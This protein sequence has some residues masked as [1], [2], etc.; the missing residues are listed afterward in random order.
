M[1]NLKKV[2]KKYITIILVILIFQVQ[3]ASAAICKH[4]TQVSKQFLAAD[5]TVEFQYDID[6]E[7]IG[8]VDFFIYLSSATTFSPTFQVAVDENP[9][10]MTTAV[11]YTFPS[12]PGNNDFGSD[13]AQL[14]SEGPNRYLLS[15]EFSSYFSFADCG[16]LSAPQLPAHRTVKVTISGL[17]VNGHLQVNA[18]S[19]GC[20]SENE[21]LVLDNSAVNFTE[22]TTCPSIAKPID[23]VLVLDVS[24]SMTEL[25]STESVTL[26]KIDILHEASNLFLNT[27]ASDT[28]CDANDRAGA[29]FFETTASPYFVAGS[30][31]VGPPTNWSTLENEVLMHPTGNTTAMGDG[32]QEAL[33][34][35]DDASNNLRYIILFTNGMQNQGNLVEDSGPP[36]FLKTLN[37][38]SLR[39][40]GIPIYT[41]GAGV[42]TGSAYEELLE[43]IAEQTGVTSTFT[44]T[45]ADDLTDAFWQ[46]LIA[47]MRG[48]SPAMV[49]V[50]AGIINKGDTSITHTFQVNRAAKSGVFIVG[51]HA[52]SNEDR[53]PQAITMEVVGPNT[54]G[55]LTQG[56]LRDDRHFHIRSVSF[57][58]SGFSANAHEGVWKIII[59]SKNMKGTKAYYHTA[60][61]VDEAKLDYRVGAAPSDYGTGEDILLTASL[62]VEGQPVKNADP[63][64]CSV[65]RPK[66]P[67]GTFLNQR[68]LSDSQLNNNPPGVHE[69]NFPNAYSRKLYRLIV[70]QGLGKLLEPI[71]ETKPIALYDDG[72]EELHGDA[73]AGDGIYSV[74]YKNT[75]IP[76]QYKFNFSI[77]G[78]HAVIGKFS[79]TEESTV[80]VRVKTADP[81]ESEIY[82]D[83]LLS[84]DKLLTVVPADRFGNFLGPGYDNEV[85]ITTNNP[86]VTVTA[87]KDERVNGTYTT[88]LKNVPPGADPEVTVMVRGKELAKKPLSQWVLPPKWILGGYFGRNLP[89]KNLD[90][91]YNPGLSIEGVLE[92]LFSNRVAVFASVGYNI[93]KHDIDVAG[94]VPVDLKAINVSGNLKVYPVIGTFQLSIFGGGGYYLFDP[95][96]DK[97]G[98]NCGTAAEL[99]ISTNFSIEAKCNYNYVFTPI[100]KTIFFTLQGGLRYRF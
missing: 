48:N 37:G 27:W 31:L 17:T 42:T 91:L 5:G 12:V 2:F 64:Q 25:A 76:G 34:R 89:R 8:R 30:F 40:Y 57:P 4:S 92:Y 23:V 81:G 36:D 96:D 47:T 93:F 6:N 94:V 38:F 98:L 51:W 44:K 72:N 41:I 74:L 63:V 62:S 26:R 75:K 29:V 82:H 61:I 55:T 20:E 28:L 49:G 53:N 22:E 10:D 95:G 18:V 54:I 13:Y 60:L 35:F 24:G 7:H 16:L 78:E 39:S 21:I 9:D 84:G 69:D 97:F 43:D 87:V 33:N 14:T 99:R 59:N 56:V 88:T 52:F 86:A 79:R 77:Q 19:K 50:H 65:T 67:L 83:N 70:E 100:E 3:Y 32:L 73:K 90:I 46:T 68:D 11:A 85:S 71:T 80:V 66:L 58:L 1:N 15:V 45:I